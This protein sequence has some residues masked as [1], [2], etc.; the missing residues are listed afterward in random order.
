MRLTPVLPDPY[1]YPQWHIH[2]HYTL[3]LFPDQL[4]H[5]LQL[6]LRDLEDQFVMDL[7]GHEAFQVIFPYAV[8]D[9]YHGQLYYICG[10]PLDRRVYG[11]PLSELADRSPLTRKLRNRPLPSKQRPHITVS[12]SLLQGLVNKV[13]Y[14][15]VMLEVC[16]YIP[17]GV[18]LGYSQVLGKAEG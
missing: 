18:P 15:L 11:S 12:L 14:T 7:E 6:I 5:G 17:L 4:L 9:V 16:V 13:A 8:E 1:I 3:H 10:C 2:L